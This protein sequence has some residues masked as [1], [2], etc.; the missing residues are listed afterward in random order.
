MRLLR[1]LTGLQTGARN[2]ALPACLGLLICTGLALSA[3]AS[4]IKDDT[5]GLSANSGMV[6]APDTDTGSNATDGPVRMARFSY[7]SGDVTWRGD[8]DG[9]WS[10][11]SGNLPLRQGAQIWATEGGRAEI[12]FDDGSRLRLDSGTV[13]TLQTL[14]SDADGEFT[15]ITL[16]EGHAA[17]RL[18][19]E[20]SIY[21]VNTPIV[22]AK[23]AGPATLRID[24][25]SGAQV[26]VEEG[27]VT[28]E[29]KQGKTDM[30]SEDYLD[31][32]D[33]G[34][35][36]DLHKLP[37]PDA[38]DSWIAD[39]D[40]QIDAIRNQPTHHLPPN[41]AIVADDLDSYGTW[42]TDPSYGDVW[43][44]RVAAAE[45]RPYHS[46]RWVWVEPFGWTWVASEPWG[47]APY[48][49]GTWVHASY[50]WG[51]V[52]GPR[53]QYWSPAVV[54]FY[55][56][57]GSVAWCALAP[58]EVHYP[59]ALAIGYRHG[60][61]ALSFSIGGAAVYYPTSGR[62]CEPRP[63]RTAYVN[64]VTYV[65]KTVYNTTVINQTIVN[66][67]T[68]ITRT[69]FV[70]LNARLA[71]GATMADARTF[72]GQG[73]Y[74]PVARGSVAMFTHG[75]E[76][77]APPVGQR[78][79]GG[80]QIVRPTALALTPSRIYRP[81]RNVSQS[82]IERPVFRAPVDA[83]IARTSR[84][85]ARTI[86]VDPA[87]RF[88]VRGSTGSP[89]TT[90]RPGTGV[91]GRPTPDTRTGVGTRT[92]TQPGTQAGTQ[93]GHPTDSGNTKTQ[94]TTGGSRSSTAAEAARRA[95]QSLGGGSRRAPQG[96]QG[97]GATTGRT[98][99]SGRATTGTRVNTDRRRD[100]QTG[101]DRSS[102]GTG[103]SGGTTRRDTGSDRSS[104]GTVT[105]GGT[106]RRDSGTDRSTTG[107]VTPGRTIRPD[108]GSDR[109]ST[110]TTTT[111]GGTGRRDTG[112][113]V[114]PHVTPRTDPPARTDRTDTGTT[115]TPRQPDVTPRRDSGSTTRRED[116]HRDT[117]PPKDNK[118][119]KDKGGSDKTKKGS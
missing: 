106:T 17:L 66:R 113:D 39:R 21:Q 60:D 33:E 43:V 62:Y 2:W 80:P 54:H 51:W 19:S 23:A 16:N 64:R 46:G 116:T 92:P 100:P 93:T 26:S 56:Y 111:P 78:P 63:W 84:P 6:G 27:H 79:V 114:T 102:T 107:T 119:T 77:A 53:T 45:W 52:P 32:P 47:W 50:G 28:V 58:R 3:P 42:R 5:L 74:R 89:V 40:R 73:V 97:V 13:I 59:S 82:I 109:T 11:A 70:P 68:Y 24:A 98:D 112:R 9:Q 20:R 22:S 115:R 96:D 83:A 61:W 104:T 117:K 25:G 15:E 44:P 41:I 118:D 29:G 75:R 88:P 65:N 8:A 7:V 86:A 31:L 94:T 35:P 101:T 36:Y 37:N 34:A 38:F 85:P 76:I 99:S 1:K 108:S 95:R 10:A 91:E 105:P 72:G 55:E 4:A 110:G 49:Y 81:E 48:H 30:Q 14:F 71:A 57:N 18:R 12:Q 87:T 90:R 67:N 69:G 103:T